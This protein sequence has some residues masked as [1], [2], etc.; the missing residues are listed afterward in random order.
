VAGVVSTQLEHAAS[1]SAP[2][3]RPCSGGAAGPAWPPS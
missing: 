2:G 1:I 3:G